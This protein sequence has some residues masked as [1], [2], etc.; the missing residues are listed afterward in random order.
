MKNWTDEE[1]DDPSPKTAIP[2]APAPIARRSRSTP[3]TCVASHE[4]PR[5]SAIEIAPITARV[6]AALCAC[7]RRNAG[8]PF[9][10][11]S[12]PVSAV[13]PEEKRLEQREQTDGPGDGRRVVQ[14]LHLEVH[15]GASRHASGEADR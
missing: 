5:N 1:A 7:G 13:A 12:T 8:T 10:I 4:I 14:R 15:G 9:E 3:S 11:A 2:T 6:V